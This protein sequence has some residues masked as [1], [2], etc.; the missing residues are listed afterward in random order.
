MSASGLKIVYDIQITCYDESG[1]RLDNI[2]FK[3]CDFGLAK[4]IQ[5]KHY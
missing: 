2:E 3:I 4:N 5:N 1:N